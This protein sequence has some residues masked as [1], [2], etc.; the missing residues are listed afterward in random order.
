MYLFISAL[1]RLRF[2]LLKNYCLAMMVG[3]LEEGALRTITPLLGLL[4][5]GS[6]TRVGQNLRSRFVLEM[7]LFQ[8]V[9]KAWIVARFRTFSCRGSSGLSSW[10]IR[11]NRQLRS[12]SLMGLRLGTT[13]CL[14]TVQ[15]WAKMILATSIARCRTRLC[16]R[17]GWDSI[18]ACI[19]GPRGI[20]SFA[21]LNEPLLQASVYQYVGICV[22][23]ALYPTS[24]CLVVNC[25]R[26]NPI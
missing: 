24:C 26:T 9:T 2:P 10:P 3:P 16:H 1:S 11:A 7:L 22:Y 4:T 21:L 5:A 23:I 19:N 18:G 14:G 20:C 8:S 15:T 25:L 12:S 13:L 6:R 17:N